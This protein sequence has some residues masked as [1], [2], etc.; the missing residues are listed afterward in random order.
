MPG[1]LRRTATACASNDGEDSSR[2]MR[3]SFI[4]SPGTARTE[5]LHAVVLPSQMIFIP[6]IR[7]GPV[8]VNC[9]NK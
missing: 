6:V 7:Q 5:K 4:G 9:R 1:R 2:H 3:E 8:A